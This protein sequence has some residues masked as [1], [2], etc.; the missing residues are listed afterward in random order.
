MEKLQLREKEIFEALKK[1]SKFKFVIIGGYAV[2]P[3]T[4]PRFS[5]DC[6]IALSDY[7]EL[8]KIGKE[9]ENNNYK[10]K[11]T[12]KIDLPY[13][14][15][16]IRYEK[17]IKDDINAS[18][19]ILIK[20]VYDRETKVSFDTEWIF[21]NSNL[22]LLRGKTIDEKLKVRII[23]IDALIVMKFISCRESDIRDLFMLT[24]K[25]KNPRWIKDEISKRHNFNGRS[26]KI[27]D[28]INSTEF[29]DNLQGVYGK[30]DDKTFEKY[31][32]AL[33]NMIKLQ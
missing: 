4:I 22:T 31:K 8:K 23:N 24:A 30:T 29:R 33:L 16:F 7:N 3:Y 2:N 32:K 12:D 10:K 27:K 13:H 6:D 20:S 18:F 11:S 26:T 9:L 21:D 25:C 1:I 14:G 28:K 19:D 17:N 15:D 5:V